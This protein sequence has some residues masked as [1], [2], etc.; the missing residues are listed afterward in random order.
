[1]EGIQTHSLNA[2]RRKFR[3]LPTDF[4]I[5]LRSKPCCSFARLPTNRKK[6]NVF[7]IWL[8]Y[9]YAYHNF[10]SSFPSSP[11]SE[12]TMVF[13]PFLSPPQQQA[14]EYFAWEFSRRKSFVA[15]KCIMLSALWHFSAA[16]R[17]FSFKCLLSLTIKEEDNIFLQP[18]TRYVRHIM[19]ALACQLRLPL[20]AAVRRAILPSNHRVV[21]IYLRLFSAARWWWR[22]IFMAKR[23]S[24]LGSRAS[25]RSKID[26]KLVRNLKH[27]RWWWMLLLRV[28]KSASPSTATNLINPWPQPSPTLPDPKDK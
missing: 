2:I 26:D 8:H 12:T 13:L 7:R 25:C 6:K 9:T 17:L 15:G 28:D 23:T 27:R 11:E 24:S 16:P 3:K 1:M 20:I 14:R 10:S 19:I 21:M 22:V 4:L 18:A 5:K